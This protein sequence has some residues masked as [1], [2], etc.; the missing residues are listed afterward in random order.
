[1]R[2][3]KEQLKKRMEVLLKES[4][5]LHDLLHDYEQVSESPYREQVINQIR[6]QLSMIGME[7]QAIHAVLGSFEDEADVDEMFWK[8][9]FPGYQ[10]K[11]PGGDKLMPE[12]KIPSPNIKVGKIGFE[13]QRKIGEIMELLTDGHACGDLD[14]K[15]LRGKLAELQVS[16][17]E[18]E[19]VLSKSEQPME[20]NEDEFKKD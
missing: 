6:P 18:F 7:R 20:V 4:T 10:F 11:V 3:K 17:F 2:T 16:Y 12:G 5:F 19:K 1:M 14:F 13:W 8:G 15:A 9:G